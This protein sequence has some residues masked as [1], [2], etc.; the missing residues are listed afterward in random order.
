MLGVLLLIA[1]GAAW[2]AIAVQLE[3]WARAQER[4]VQRRACLGGPVGRP[5]D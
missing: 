1:H 2:V 5:G 4:R 3:V